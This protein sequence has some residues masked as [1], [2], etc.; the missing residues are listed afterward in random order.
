[1]NR[2][3]K[4][5]EGRGQKKYSISLLKL[6]L[7]LLHCLRLKQK[8]VKKKIIKHL[9]RIS[10]WQN[11]L[12]MA[13][14]VPW[15]RFIKLLFPYGKNKLCPKNGALAGVELECKNYRGITLLNIA[16]KVLSCI[17]LECINHYT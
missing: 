7:N 6:R 11:F 16:Y 4:Y 13:D 3:D 5:F 15:M 17:I 12:R 8:Y 1:M 9:V 10:L 2:W 14:R